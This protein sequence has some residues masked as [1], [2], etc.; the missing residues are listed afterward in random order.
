MALGATSGDI[1]RLIVGQGMRLALLGV[2]VGLI[3][4]LALTRLISSLLFGVRA[5]DPLAFGIAAI[6]L[7]FT[8]LAACYLPAWRAT[9]VDPMV[10]LR[11]E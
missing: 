7:V 4:S 5:A 6:A 2:A 10:V 8:A 1:L 11:H 9:L 3:A